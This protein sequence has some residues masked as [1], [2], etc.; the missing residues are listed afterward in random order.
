MDIYQE[1]YKDD[2]F[3]YLCSLEKQYV[4]EKIK[5][6]M[7]PNFENRMRYLCIRWMS[8]IVANQILFSPVI[9]LLKFILTKNCFKYF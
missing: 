8:R 4:Q 3:Q 6:E 7:R 9:F 5:P 1:G 2:Y